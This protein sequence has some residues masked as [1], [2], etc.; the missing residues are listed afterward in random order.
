MLKN[1]R[2]SKKL[3]ILVGFLILCI[4]SVSAMSFFSMYRINDAS[5][6]ITKNW[7]PSVIIAED[8]N[9]LTSDYKI[10]ELEHM[11][12]ATSA[13]KEKYL[14]ELESKQHEI[15]A[16]FAA[17]EPLVTNDIDRALMETAKQKWSDYLVISQQVLQ[18][19]TQ[20][21]IQKALTLSEEQG[22]SLFQDAS[23][24]LLQVV[25][26]NKEGADAASAQGD[27]LYLL[28]IVVFSGVA[29]AVLIISVIFSFFII[30]NITKPLAEISNA[31]EKISNGNLEFELQ[32]VSEDEIGNMAKAFRGMQSV[33]TVIIQDIGYLLG[34]MAGGNFAIKTNCEEQYI[35][36]FEKIKLAIRR[37]N[38]TLNDTIYEVDISAKQVASGADQV[39]AGAQA[40]SQG[41]TEQASAIE[42]LSASL[43]DIANQVK[44]N[45]ENAKAANIKAISAGKSLNICTGQ[46]NEM[47]GAMG[48]I[49][50]KSTQISKIIKVID[51]IAFQTNILALNAAVEAARAGVAG[52][53]FAVVADEVRNLA[54][55][56]ANAAKDTTGLIEETIE[57]VNN[58]AN[59]LT[60]TS[61]A[62][63]DS[64]QVTNEVVSLIEKISEASNGQADSIAQVNVGVDQVSAVVQT[65]SATS[66][67]SAATSEELSAHAHSLQ[68]LTGKFKLRQHHM[69]AEQ[70]TTT[71]SA[72]A[73]N[74]AATTFSTPNSEKY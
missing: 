30:N 35:G 49:S 72:E 23:S 20:A 67:E 63:H 43:A 41:A 14:A 59:I 55:K 21:Q 1:L 58:G 73:S 45:A 62:L 22:L 15:E 31:A 60:M 57:A 52:R 5:T 3:W 17:Y 12:A 51:D 36:E 53:G 46:M 39:S 70:N 34:E 42:E 10:L 40:L 74:A 56:S 25:E 16:Q 68:N 47:V 61:N 19:S 33:L 26:F 4:I 66:E 37:L 18:L 7:L 11:N 28:S 13:A 64:A 44:R 29:A 38:R 65:N 27:A 48:N 69:M 2:I 54:S 8:L 24:T 50:D 71:V 6:I 32:H 9:T